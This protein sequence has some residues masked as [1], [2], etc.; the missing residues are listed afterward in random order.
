MDTMAP[1]LSNLLLL[2]LVAVTKI[3]ENEKDSLL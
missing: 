1:K 2:G 3:L